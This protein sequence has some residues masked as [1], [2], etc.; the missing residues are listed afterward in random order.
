M[1]SGAPVVPVSIVGATRLLPKGSLNLKSGTITVTFHAPLHP[2][3]YSEKE[4]LMA[5]V[6]DAIEAGLRTPGQTPIVN[7][8]ATSR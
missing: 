3:D 5:A 7:T 4:D 1:N 8:A 6:R 2:A